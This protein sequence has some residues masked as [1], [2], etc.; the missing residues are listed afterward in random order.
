MAQPGRCG[1][2]Y[3]PDIWMDLMHPA[4]LQ[5]SGSP[6]PPSQP[7]LINLSMERRRCLHII[8]ASFQSHISRNNIEMTCLCSCRVQRLVPPLHLTSLAKSLGHRTSRGHPGSKSTEHVMTGSDIHIPGPNP[9]RPTQPV[10][11]LELP[12]NQARTP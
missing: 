2:T 9:P 6:S 3:A 5:F 12:Q 11:G 1:P 4:R 10:A 7:R 8:V